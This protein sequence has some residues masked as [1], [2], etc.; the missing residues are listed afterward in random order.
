M[1]ARLVAFIKRFGLALLVAVAIAAVFATGLA[2]HLS[3][4]E[5]RERRETLLAFAHAHPI[6]GV[7]AYI[8][9]FA[10]VTA[11]SLP[12]EPPMSLAGGLLFGT[13]VG[14]L[15][16]ALGC[17]IGGTV[18][19][20]ACRTAAGDTLRRWAGPRVAA[21]E[22]GVKRDAFFYILTLRLIP[23]LPFG[24]TTVALGFV[25]I[26]LTTFIAASFLGILPISLIYASFGA[27]LNRVFASHE[28]L[29]L[30]TLVQPQLLFALVGLAL[31]A[32]APIAV[33]RWRRARAGSRVAGPPPVE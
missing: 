18:L 26:R 25:E 29:H 4:H 6:L 13:V 28:R 17:T 1:G 15:A 16:A 24:L 21:F 10:A 11:L 2:R 33:R 20:L 22:E 8:G 32:L 31:L 9:G 12:V 19:F 30:R 7:I 5:L 14:G 23:V 27:D 3:L